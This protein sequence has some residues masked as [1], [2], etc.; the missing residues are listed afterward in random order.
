MSKKKT[1][2]RV[3]RKVLPG[4]VDFKQFWQD[5]GPFTYALTSN[6]FPPVL[7]EEEEWIFSNSMTDLLKELMGFDIHKMKVIKA[8]FNPDNE[9]VLR[10]ERLSIWKINKFPQ[11]WDSMTCNLFVP[12]GH[13]TKD[14]FDL[15]DMDQDNADADM[16]EKA[17]FINLANCIEELGY[18]ILAPQGKAKNASIHSYLKEWEEDDKEAG[19]L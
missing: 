14:F 6:E 11:E 4:S 15:T 9:A 2:K 7:L 8:P 18:R 10:P 16:I 19:L 13:L 12:Q 5:E 17:F 1:K 3:L